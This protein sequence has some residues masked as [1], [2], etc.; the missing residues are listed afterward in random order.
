VV[1]EALKRAGGGAILNIATGPGSDTAFLAD[2]FPDTRI[3]GLDPDLASMGQFFLNMSGRKNVTG[4]VARAEDYEELLRA[5]AQNPELR[6]RL[7]EKG[8]LPEQ[9]AVV[10]MHFG[11]HHWQRGHRSGFQDPALRLLK[12]GGTLASGDEYLP[13]E[14]ELARAHDVYHIEGVIADAH[15]IGDEALVDLEDAARLSGLLALSGDPSGCDYKQPVFAEVEECERALSVSAGRDPS[16][17]KKAVTA[18]EDRLRYVAHAGA[19]ASGPIEIWPVWVVGGRPAIPTSPERD[20]HRL[21]ELDRRG[22]IA[23]LCVRKAA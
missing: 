9:V 4:L 1:G 13:S 23:V 16:E 15:E 2:C 20:P 12:P 6:R 5:A 21:I 7:D 11:G 17:V 8:I 14:Y 18:R 10:V 3:I 19:V 22:G